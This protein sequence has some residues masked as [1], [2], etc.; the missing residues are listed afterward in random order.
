MALELKPSV[1]AALPITVK[2][3]L[4]KMSLEEQLMFQEMFEK[5]SKSLAP[6][7]L[8]AVLFPIQHFLL[9]KTGLGIVF[10]LTGGGLWI[11]WIIEWFLTPRRVREYNEDV[12]TK[13]LMDIKI[14]NS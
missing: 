4:A 2:T 1:M 8:L 3:A 7:L 9:G 13:L 14:M 5:K 11:W 6:M 10:F 12:A